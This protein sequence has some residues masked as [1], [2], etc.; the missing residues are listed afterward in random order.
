MTRP[1]TG[2]VAAAIVVHSASHFRD[3]TAEFL[4]SWEE[5]AH[6]VSA[7]LL[8]VNNN[9]PAWAD[10]VLAQLPNVTVIHQAH[11]E[12]YSRNLNAALERASNHEFF[13]AMNPDMRLGAGNLELMTR[14]MREHPKCG[15]GT[16]K[17]L[18][19]SG[20]L[21]HNCRRWQSAR[22]AAA[23]RLPWFP[24]S[25]GVVRRYLMIDE[26]YEREATPDWVSGC[27]MFFRQ[28]L[29]TQLGG[30]DEGFRLY[31]EDCDIALRIWESGHTVNFTPAPVCYHREHRQ[32]TS[33]LSWHGRT[34]LR[35][36]LRSTYKHLFVYG[37][38]RR[39]KRESSS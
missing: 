35:S 31:F 9:C 29:L 36:W 30:F 13:L 38:G 10:D 39:N 21:Q 19:F 32:S 25:A 6:G 14:F 23:R 4:P 37:K 5:G 34:H 7:D 20:D 24:G 2:D 27:Y 18:S 26:A 11:W 33:L 28:P 12:G 22:I 8:V 1:T 3:L 16:C 17:L 15:L